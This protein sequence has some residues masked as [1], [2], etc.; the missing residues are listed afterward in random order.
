MNARVR[1]LLSITDSIA[2]ILMAL[3]LHYY[4]TPS[5][6]LLPSPNPPPGPIP[7]VAVAEYDSLIRMKLSGFAAYLTLYVKKLGS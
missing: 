7:G 4:S 6:I 2:R 1:N 3:H 5:P